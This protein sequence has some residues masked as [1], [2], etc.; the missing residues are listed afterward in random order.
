MSHTPIP[1]FDRCTL[2]LLHYMQSDVFSFGMVLFEL[3]SRTM[4]ACTELLPFHLDADPAVQFANKVAT[5]GYRPP[6]AD[7]ISDKVWGLICQCW[8]EDPK[9]RP[10]MPYVVMELESIIAD[11][12]YVPLPDML[13]DAEAAASVDGTMPESSVQ[14]N[15]RHGNGGSLSS[16]GQGSQGQGTVGVAGKEEELPQPPGCSCVIC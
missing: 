15:G 2:C 4:I 7:C 10:H 16:N 14:Q 12:S 8:D 3:M 1:P 13:D 9:K 5:Q 11:G 6:R